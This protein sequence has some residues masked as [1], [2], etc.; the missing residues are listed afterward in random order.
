MKQPATYIS[1]IEM[2][3]MFHVEKIINVSFSNKIKKFFL[4]NEKHM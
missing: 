2:F 4:L 1:L 3:N